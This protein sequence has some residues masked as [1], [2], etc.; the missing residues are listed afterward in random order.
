MRHLEFAHAL[1]KLYV[2]PGD[3][4]VDATAGNGH[5]CLTLLEMGLQL[6]AFDIQEEA[7]NATRERLHMFSK[8]RYSLHLLC[9][10][11]MEQ[12]LELNSAKLIVFNLGYL[13]GSD[14]SC[15]TL[16]P[17][18]LQAIEASMRAVAPGGLISITCYPGHPEGAVE[19]AAILSILKN[20]DPKAWHYSSHSFPNRPKHPHLLLIQKIIV[21]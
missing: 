17:T 4:A 7:L 20:L 21:E 3:L 15:T 18:T 16:T 9:H 14:K 1:W 6:V 12:V 10:S 19:E 2:A 5:D 8:E 11:K 13:P